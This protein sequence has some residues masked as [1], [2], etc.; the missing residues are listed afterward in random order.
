MKNEG[1]IERQEGK[2]K[3]N[4][5]SFRRD[6]MIYMFTHLGNE[7]TK[8]RMRSRQLLNVGDFQLNHLVGSTWI[9]W[10]L[11]IYHGYRYEGIRGGIELGN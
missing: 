9:V 10:I 11:T 2:A 4:V 6:P 5:R 1:I 8:V 3:F 7:R